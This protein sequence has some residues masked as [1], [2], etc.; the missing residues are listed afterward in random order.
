MVDRLL[1]INLI[2]YYNIINHSYC[3]Y[4]FIYSFQFT[5]ILWYNIYVEYIDAKTILSG[6]FESSNWFG[7]NYNMNLY[8]GCAH[9]CIYCDSRSECYQI[10]EFDRVRTKKNAL[11]ILEN[12][13]RTKRKKGVIGMGGMS[14]TY[15]PF[16]KDLQITRNALKL[17]D[18]YHFG[19]GIS[20]KSDLIIRDIDVFKSIMRHSPVT[21]KF[22]V[23]A[24]GDEMSKLIEPNVVPSSKRFSALKKMTDNGIFAGILMMPILPFILDAPENILS[25]VDKVHESGGKFIYSGFGVTLRQNQRAWYYYALDKHFK[26]IKQKYINKY[27]NR[28]ECGI[29][30]HE[31]ISNLFKERCEKHRIKYKMQDIIDESRKG[32][33]KEQISFF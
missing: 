15:N 11:E 29:P 22:T 1:I 13:L 19:L 2:Y 10:E 6:Y 26:G 33:N 30:N 3:K 8:K 31:K 23:T 16:E 5:S 32:Y 4:L 20:T 25:I 17:I 27:G 7:H 21:V 18:K 14:D 9:G 12:E 24:A 28:Y